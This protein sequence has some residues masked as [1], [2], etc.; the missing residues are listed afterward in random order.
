MADEA[1]FFILCMLIGTECLLMRGF[2][3]KGYGKN[4]FQK[5]C[6]SGNKTGF[7]SG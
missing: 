3:K 4:E 5:S 6:H 7:L 2:M 1:S